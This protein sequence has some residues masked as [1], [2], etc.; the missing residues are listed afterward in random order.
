[1]LSNIFA[2]NIINDGYPGMIYKLFGKIFWVWNT[3]SIIVKVLKKLFFRSFL[4]LFESYAL[5]SGFLFVVT[6]L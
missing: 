1:M 4:S 3:L 2:E 6:N 5:I